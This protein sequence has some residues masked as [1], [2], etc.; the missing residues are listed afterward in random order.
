MKKVT[1]IIICTLLGLRTIAQIP[2]SRV[3]DAAMPNGAIRLTN[4]QLKDYI[5]NNYKKSGVPLDKDNVY[6]IDGVIISFW[7]LHVNPQFKKSLE[8]SQ[9]EILG[10]LK[11]TDHNNVNFSKIITVKGVRYLE[12][13][14]QKYDEVFLRFQSEFD[15][16]NDN[17]CGIVQC[18]EPDRQKAE[19]TLDNF[20]QTVH[21]KVQ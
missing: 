15:S 10:Y 7:D 21:F 20:L 4:E 9:K 8:A 2:K 16:N 17:I 11:W 1:L 5:R 19:E 13:E 6:Q 14:Y 12:Y 3:V 18:K